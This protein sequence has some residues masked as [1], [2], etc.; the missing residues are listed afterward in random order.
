MMRF[1]TGLLLA[2]ALVF[3]TPALATEARGAD[4]FEAGV[5]AFRAG[6]Y[7]A[8]L[9]AFRAAQRQGLKSA[10]LDLNLGLAHYR[11][12]QFYEARG[13]FEK[14][15]GDL[16]YTAIADYHLGLM[17][18]QLGDREAALYH[19]QS[20]Q[21]LA[22]SPALRD[23]AT[24]ALRRL[25]DVPLEEEPATADVEQPD[26]S[27]F[28]R[29][30]TGFDSNPELVNDTLDRPVETEGAGYAELRGNLEHPL[31]ATGL[32]T[33]L[34][35]ADL[36]VRQHDGEEGFDWQSGELG[37]RQAWRARG[38]RLG[39]G[40]EG[41]AGW[42][43]GEACQSTGTAIVD[44]RRR[45][46]P[47]GLM[48]RYEAQRV[49]GEGQ[50]AYLDGWRHRGEL[51]L[52]RSVRSLR[53]RMKLEY[54]ANDRRDLTVGEEFSSYSPTRRGIGLAVATPPLRHVTTELRAR[55][56]DSRYPE[57]NRFLEG[58][59]LREERRH[60]RLASAGLRI[61]LRA[62]ET[63]NWLLDFQY[64]RNDSSLEAFD[65]ARQVAALGIEWLR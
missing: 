14:V 49:A 41:G 5:T 12:G 32:G 59:S 38:W 17:A 58:G 56:R 36:S 61:R 60:D 51:E 31:A 62:G 18:A 33:T 22:S 16:R 11:L 4:A 24:V 7:R 46:G 1:G 65:Y 21:A 45:L 64:H 30:A 25:D 35:R 8:A 47:V 23:Q 53:G 15:R 27:Y 6:N 50:Y 29:A 48:L 52:A 10:N 40:A 42:V 55:Y 54:E 63:W 28:L 44:G 43:D 37:L 20:V 26:G 13:H 39:L 3:G 34:F 57:A 2:W 9:D 19:L